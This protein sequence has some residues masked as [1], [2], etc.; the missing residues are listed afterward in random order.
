MQGIA[1]VTVR[2]WV[3]AVAIAAVLL[4]SVWTRVDPR[5]TDAE[6]RHATDIASFVAASRA[7][8]RGMDP[9]DVAVTRTHVP[10][11]AATVMPYVYSPILA[12]V[13]RPI[14]AHSLAS[15]QRWWLVLGTASL[16]LFVVLLTG[17]AADRQWTGSDAPTTATRP[18]LAVLLALLLPL[19]FTLV[20]GQVEAFLAPLVGLAVWCTLRGR[21]VAAG[22][23]LGSVIAIKHAAVF[24]L[25][26]FVLRRDWRTIGTAMI[27]LMVVV[28]GSVVIGGADVWWSFLQW[29]SSMS[30]ERAVLQGFDPGDGY[31]LSW[32][33]LLIRLGAEPA[34]AF[35]WAGPSIL[36]VVMAVV[37]MRLRS[38]QMA[39]YRSY[40]AASLTAVLALPFAWSHHLLY[41]GPALATIFARPIALNERSV[42]ITAVIAAVGLQVAPGMPLDRLL[43]YAGVEL[44]VAVYGSLAT[45]L[46]FMLALRVVSRRA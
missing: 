19:H 9:Y 44:P 37:A 21:W 14:S 34:V 1:T 29:A 4:A 17:F 23:L 33:G 12:Q 16:S 40:L 45:I 2:T 6:I 26:W 7:L 38:T 25:L 43:R 35:R 15:I 41:A 20:S 32:T 5:A 13:L 10:T 42:V 39:P 27:T 8:D 11:D 36:V 30:Y 24:L 46:M 28:G 31:N 18:V 22:I 3:V